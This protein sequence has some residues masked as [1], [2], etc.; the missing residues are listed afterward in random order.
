MLTPQASLLRRE[1]PQGNWKPEETAT[2]KSQPRKKSTLATCSQT[3]DSVLMVLV[4]QTVTTKYLRLGDYP[5]LEAGKF[6]VKGPADS[7]FGEGMYL[8]S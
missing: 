1:T 7:V 3:D 2:G 5:M 6:K 8:G 4:Y